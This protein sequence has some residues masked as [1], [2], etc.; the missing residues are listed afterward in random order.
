MTTPR[1][2][3]GPLVALA[4]LAALATGACGKAREAAAPA[5]PGGAG[6]PPGRQLTIGAVIYGEYT[7]SKLVRQELLRRGAAQGVRVELRKHDHVLTEEARLLRE[8][9]AQRV[10]AMIVYIQDPEASVPAVRA[11]HAAGIPIVCVGSCLNEEDTKKYIE[12]FYEAD[13]T[14]MGYRSGIYL[15]QWAAEHI[16]G[17]VR[18]GLLNCNRIPACRSRSQGFRDALDDSGLEWIPVADREGYE[19][20]T[21]K[22][23]AKGILTEYPDVQILFAANQSGTEGEVEAVREMALQG[24]VHVFSTDYGDEIARMLASPDGVLQA[25][26]GQ[27]STEVGRQVFDGAVKLARKEKLSVRHYVVGNPFYSRP[28][29]AGEA[30]PCPDRAGAAETQR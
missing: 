26:T 4:L 30:R 8:L 20:A 14:L 25:V 2:I 19:V 18:I 24:K 1:G 28:P 16:A 7:S 21:S 15:A 10:D 11:V 17:P 3:G 22:P 5:A 9:V 6:R 13:P 27:A 29:S 12:A 23:V